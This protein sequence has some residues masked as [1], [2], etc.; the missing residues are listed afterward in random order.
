MKIIDEADHLYGYARAI[1]V[2]PTQW[3]RP[4]PASPIL[5]QA[6][7][8]QAKSQNLNY[9]MRVCHHL[10]SYHA[11][12]NPE[13]FPP[14][15]RHRIEADYVMVKRQ[16]KK[17]SMDIETATLFE[18]ARL[19]Q[20]NAASVLQTVDKEKASDPYYQKATLKQIYSTEKEFFQVIV[21]ALFSF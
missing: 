17:E 7:K 16:D 12:R 6:L 19:F 3:G 20:Q 8:M 11:L 5:V 21:A 14:Q 13:V 15:Y 2:E 10:E 18:T 9:E 4:I 1:G